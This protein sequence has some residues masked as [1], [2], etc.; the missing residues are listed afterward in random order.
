MGDQIG[1]LISF[2]GSRAK[3]AKVV[4]VTPQ[5]VHKWEKQKIPSARAIQIEQITNGEITV[6]D[7]RPDLC[8]HQ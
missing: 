8:V 5:A 3:L 7:L 6:K 2:F 4:G 1:V